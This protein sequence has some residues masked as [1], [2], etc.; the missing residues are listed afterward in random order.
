MYI[1]MVYLFLNSLAG[2]YISGKELIN[3]NIGKFFI[4]L[5]FSIIQLLIAIEIFNH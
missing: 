1:L 3:G 5:T 2:I 4:C